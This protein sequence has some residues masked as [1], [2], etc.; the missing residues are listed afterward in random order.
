MLTLVFVFMLFNLTTIWNLF[1][2]STGEH[3][4]DDILSL[5]GPA[6]QFFVRGHAWKVT[7]R[8]IPQWRQPPMILCHATLVSLVKVICLL[9]QIIL[10]LSYMGLNMAYIVQRFLHGS[11][12][13][14][15]WAFPRWCQ[16][17]IPSPLA[18]AEPL[19]PRTAL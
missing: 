8:G 2:I 18:T 19:C 13:L 16:R 3:G 10:P 7:P 12:I 14:G 17:V 11:A 9:N 6:A 15:L 4:C 5:V 1:L